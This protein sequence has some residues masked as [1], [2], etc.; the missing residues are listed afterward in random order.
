M[1]AIRSLSAARGVQVV[2]YMMT[3]LCGVQFFLTIVFVK[4]YSLR[5]D[6]DE[7]EK[8]AAKAWLK[9]RKRKGGQDVAEAQK[10]TAAGAAVRRAEETA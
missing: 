6:D 5:R 3:A 7:K 4:D 10:G 1:R 9:E 8:E 2:Y